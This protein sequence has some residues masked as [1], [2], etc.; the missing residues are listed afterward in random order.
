[1]NRRQAVYTVIAALALLLTSAATHAVTSTWITLTGTNN[2]SGANWDSAPSSG[3]DTVLQFT[4]SSSG[5]SYGATNDNYSAVPFVLNQLIFSNASSSARITLMGT[6]L[7]LTN[8]TSGTLPQLTQN[9]V[10][11]VTIT[12]KLILGAD[13]TFGGSGSGAVTVSGVVTGA[14][15]LTKTGNYTLRLSSTAN[16]YTGNVNINGGTLELASGSGTTYTGG[17]ITINSASTLLIS[18]AYVLFADKNITFGSAGG[19]TLIVNSESSGFLIRGSVG[20]TFTTSGGARSTVSGA[21]INLDGSTRNAIFNVVRGSD[22]TVDL[23]ASV[24]FINGGSVVKTGNG[25]MT[26]SRTDSSYTGGTIINGGTLNVGTIST[27]GNGNLGNLSAST[28]TLT[29]GGGVLKYTG[30]GATISSPWKLTAGTS[31]GIDV[32]NTLTITTDAPSSTGSLTKFGVGKLILSGNNS[33]TGGTTISG[34][35]LNIANDNNL[36]G[37]AGTLTFSGGTLQFGGSGITVNASRPAAITSSGGFVD[38][39]LNSGTIASAIGGSGTLTKTGTGRLTL[40]GT[41]PYNGTTIVNGGEL[42]VNGSL[43][44]GGAV[45]VNTGAV[46]GGSGS[47]GAV[48]IANGAT[49]SPGNSAGVFNVGALTLNSGA[50]FRVQMDSVSVYDQ[51]IA[52]GV[53]NIAGSTLVLDNPLTFGPVPLGTS[54]TILTNLT[55]GAITGQFSNGN[56]ITVDDSLDNQVTFTINYNADSIVLSVIPE[57]STWALVALALMPL[58]FRRQRKL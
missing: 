9:G 53:V 5:V 37:T 30:T 4:N 39:S 2:W 57:P 1:M 56:T 32:A 33:Y 55:A 14:V 51:V 31:S 40:S 36:G 22:P 20:A 25:I 49:L 44:A 47:V 29:F 34:G 41:S 6:D 50:M 10:G 8:T 12:N 3:A 35:I 54:F 43:A 15:N 17:T 16:T 58:F 28:G 46:L 27:T 42:I 7:K 52:N 38:T 48:T 19:G 26:L 21:F 23:D 24:K 11:S 18:G 13:T 45:T